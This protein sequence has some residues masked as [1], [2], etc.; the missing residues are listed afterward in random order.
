MG[1]VWRMQYLRDN[2]CVS[3]TRFA[4]LVLVMTASAASAQPN[5]EPQRAEPGPVTRSMFNWVHTTGNA[6]RAFRFYHDVFG[7]ELAPHPFISGATAPEGIRAAA[8][9]GSDELIWDLTDTG[10]SRSRTVF[11]RAA[12]TPFGLELSEFFDI[13]RGTR[14][15]NPWDP[16]ASM[17]IF[18]VR[19]L[20]EISTRLAH[21]GAPVVTVGGRPLATVAGRS[22]LVRDPDGY[23]IEVVQAATGEIELA[24]PGEIVGTTIGI[25]VADTTAAAAFYGNLLGFEVSETRRADDSEL[26]VL[27]LT[28]GRL[29]Q[30][31]ASIPGTQVHVLISK[32][33]LAASAG[34]QAVPFQWKIQDVGA[35]QFQLEVIGLDALLE[36]TRAGGYR[37]LSV[38]ERP[39]QR[40]FGRFVFVIDPDGVL[41]EYVE[42]ARP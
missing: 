16:G 40:P 28:S 38:G 21:A 12:N 7:I 13:P 19:D 35:P 30:T 32:F 18:E 26:R 10:G 39:I 9:A 33:T 31:V 37:F 34:L 29:E 42:R 5:R 15:A 4:L 1:P 3:A 27:G 20:D 8:E 41:V 6:E 23:L 17:L 22:L 24:A 36:R 11:M 2:R 25:T 14:A